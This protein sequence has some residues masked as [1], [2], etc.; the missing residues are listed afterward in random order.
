MVPRS[1]IIQHQSHLRKILRG[2]VLY[3]NKDRLIETSRYI[4][5]NGV[6]DRRDGPHGTWANQTLKILEERQENAKILK[7]RSHS[8]TERYQKKE[9]KTY[10]SDYAQK[11][12]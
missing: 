9:K 6:K 8:T 10:R 4:K 3:D 7:H 11:V 12:V 2:T 1:F 5:A